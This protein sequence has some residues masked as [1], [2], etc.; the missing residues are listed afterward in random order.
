MAG[1][2]YHSEPD[3]EVRGLALFCDAF[4]ALSLC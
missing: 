4:D 3:A 1:Q 2:V